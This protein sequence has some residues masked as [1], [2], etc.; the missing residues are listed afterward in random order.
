MIKQRQEWNLA[1]PNFSVTCA[2][3]ELLE[4]DPDNFTLATFKHSTIPEKNNSDS[5]EISPNLTTI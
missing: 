5:N 2:R 1:Q 3:S 4:S